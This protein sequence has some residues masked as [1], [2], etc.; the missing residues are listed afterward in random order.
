M[1]RIRKK[2]WILAA[3]CLS[4]ALLWCVAAILFF[5]ARFE[6]NDDAGIANIAA[7]AL[8]EDSQYLIHVNVLLGWLLKGLNA[9]VKG[10]AWYSGFSYFLLVLGFGAV[11]FVLIERFSLKIGAPIYALLLFT[12]GTDLFCRF[13]YT[14]NSAFL[15]AVG[16][17]LI[18]RNFGNMRWGYWVGF[19]LC[20]FGS[21]LRFDSFL[22]VLAISFF[23]FL[24]YFLILAKWQRKKAILSLALLIAVCFAA[25]GADR[26]AYKLD[27]EWDDFYRFN[28][29]REEFLDYKL[30][31][32]GPPFDYYDIGVRE[33]EVEMLRDWNIFDPDFFTAEKFEELSALTN[34]QSLGEALLSFPAALTSLFF[35]NIYS[36]IAI[37]TFLLVLLQCRKQRL[38][39]ALMVF[40]VSLMGLFA[41]HWIGR[42]IAR[43]ETSFLL[44][45]VLYVLFLIEKVEEKN[46]QLVVL[47]LTALA[48]A[49]SVFF[50]TGLKQDNDYYLGSRIGTVEELNDF[51]NDKQ[52]LYL[53]DTEH[54]DNAM[55]YDVFHPRQAGYF[56][57]LVF[58]GGWLSNSPYQLRTL[59]RYEIE[60]P[61][62]DMVNNDRIFLAG[63]VNI[64][65]VNKYINMHY[66]VYARL[67]E[68][69]KDLFQIISEG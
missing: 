69:K 64:H 7:G 33:P 44:A 16:L 24:F 18:L 58:L 1:W 43:V 8:G 45:A 66:D 23:A 2:K 57:N 39:S 54:F 9:I 55:G 62:R 68:P 50:L 49:A 52:N 59:E 67:V 27:P 46:R 15:I 13:Q 31:S 14:K 11:G 36:V 22:P 56:D 26:L 53:L 17:L 40:A 63:S 12:A 21:L 41:L 6:T 28:A 3:G 30:D 19:G 5:G 47:G 38:F 20:L 60:N 37:F 25:F 48:C 29:A 42:M 51:V 35:G 32:I 61:Y 34:R 65:D 10:F 4:A